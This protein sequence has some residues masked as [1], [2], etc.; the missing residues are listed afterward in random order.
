MT[1]RDSRRWLGFSLGIALA[2]AAILWSLYGGRGVVETENAY[3]KAGKFSLSAD[4]AGLVA[5][6]PVHPNQRVARNQVLVRLD[7]TSFR[8]SVAESEAHLAQVRNEVMARRADYAEAEVELTQAMNDVS[9]YERKLS[10]NEK[11]GPVAVSEAQ[12]DDARQQ[13]IAA[14]SKI[15]AYRQKLSSLRAELG[16]NPDLPL[17]QQA[18]IMVAQAQLDRARYQLSRTVVR[19]PEE[20]FVANEV[21]QVGEMAA[22]GLSLVSMISA[23]SVWVEANLKETQLDGVRP[24]QTARVTVDAYPD[25]VWMAEVQSLS[26]A[27]GSEFALIPAQNASGNWVKVVQRIPVHLR[28][29]IHEGEPALRAGMSA[30]V[31]IEVSPD[32][33]RAAATEPVYSQLGNVA[34]GQ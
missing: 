12:L 4:V 21:P 23:E 19:A 29:E 18:D 2:A 27:S 7:D 32:R 3:V 20:G 1:N 17:E 22:A 15:S 31:S 25:H 9:Y 13:L 11:M 8:L 24:G 5:E 30:R 16:G 28:L 34:A 6:V 14:R 26:P 10:R 33:P